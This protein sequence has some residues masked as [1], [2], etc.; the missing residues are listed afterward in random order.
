MAASGVKA[1]SSSSRAPNTPLRVLCLHGGGGNKIVMNAQTRKLRQLLGA[2]VV[3][4]FLEGPRIYP[5]EEVGA[6]ASR[7]PT[8]TAEI[9]R[10]STH[11]V[12]QVDKT[13]INYFGKGPYYGW[14]GVENDGDPERNYIEK[15][16]DYSVVFTYSAVETA[17]A[18]LEKALDERG[19]FDVLL[20]FSQGACAS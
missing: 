18:T 19:P 7:Q 5:Q 20:G 1:S 4:E 16:N 2:D 12:A 11:G 15:L 10:G 3:F 17:L 14:Y 8:S 9:H 13:L 6:A